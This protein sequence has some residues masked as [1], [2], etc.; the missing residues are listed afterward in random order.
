MAKY[1]KK[2][3]TVDAIQFNG[4]T[5]SGEPRFNRR[6]GKSNPKWLREAM[7]EDEREPGAVYLGAGWHPPKMMVFSRE[8]ILMAD[9]GDWI[10]R[11]AEGEV[12]PVKA[13]D[14]ANSFDKV[15]A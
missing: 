14:F 10:V 15:E 2:Q 8:G 9:V 5:E 12:Y 6:S 13:K 3:S 11:G 7:D 4:L 1:T